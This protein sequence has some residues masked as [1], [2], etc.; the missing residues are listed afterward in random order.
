MPRETQDPSSMNGPDDRHPMSVHLI[1]ETLKLIDEKGGCK[2]V[3]LRR[4]AERAGCAHTNTY[5]Y[6]DSLDGLLWAAM[7]ESLARLE[8]FVNEALNPEQVSGNPLRIFLDAQLDYS[9]NHPGQYRLFWMEPLKGAAPG[10]VLSSLERMRVMWVRMIAGS[11]SATSSNEKL[12]WAGQLVHGYFHGEICKVI[13]RSAF[14]A[15]V[16]AERDRI[17]RNIFSLVSLI[18]DSPDPPS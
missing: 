12:R 8:A 5:N 3:N 10:N 17:V 4:I 9:L 6:F 16:E 11:V 2:G 13:G 14:V 18:A 7:D 15:N 1:R